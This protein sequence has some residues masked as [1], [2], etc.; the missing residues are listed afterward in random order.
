MFKDPPQFTNV[1][2]TPSVPECYKED[3]SWVQVGK[4]LARNNLNAAENNV[5]KAPVNPRDGTG[6]HIFIFLISYFL[7]LYKSY[8]FF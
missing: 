4:D 7:P 3:G 5:L 6:L 8:V 1:K 2:G